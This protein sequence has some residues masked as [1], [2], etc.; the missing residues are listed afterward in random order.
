MKKKVLFLAGFVA[1]CTI[2]ANAQWTVIDPTNVAESIKIFE[3]AKQLYSQGQQIYSQARQVAGFVRSAGGWKTLL[4][5]TSYSLG[6]PSLGNDITALAQIKRSN[7]AAKDILNRI[8]NDAGWQPTAENAAIIQMLHLETV[9]GVMQENQMQDQLN[10]DIQRIS[11]L[12]M[13]PRTSMDG[14]FTAGYRQQ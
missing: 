12:R 4:N 3:Q 9:K 13:A 2:P 7:Q 5:N 11:A 6:M 14:I 10:R 8:T 1:V